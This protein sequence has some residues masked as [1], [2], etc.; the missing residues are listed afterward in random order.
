MAIAM[1]HTAPRRPE[2]E[3]IAA[4]ASAGQTLHR[5]AHASGPGGYW[6]S[7]GTTGAEEAKAFFGLGP[8]DRLLGFFQLGCIETPSA[9]GRRGPVQGKTPWVSE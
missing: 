4:G 3:E 6:R 9:P 7:G 5:S 2:T 1:Q 8:D